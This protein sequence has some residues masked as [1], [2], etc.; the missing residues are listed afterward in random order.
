MFAQSFGMSEDDV[1]P[2]KM[3]I[4]RKSLARTLTSS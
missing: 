3:Q 2:K 4:I 1:L